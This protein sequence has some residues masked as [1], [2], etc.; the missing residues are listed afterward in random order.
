MNQ[1]ILTQFVRLFTLGD[2]AATQRVGK[3][4]ALA[5]R[6]PTAYQTQFAEELEERGILTAL[7]EQE[8]RDIALIDALSIED[9]AWENDWK[10]DAAE[11]AEGLNEILTRQQRGYALPTSTLPGGRN[12][13]AEAL[14]ALQDALEVKG[15]ALVLFTLD[16]DSYPLGIVDDAQAEEARRL[17]KKLGFNITVY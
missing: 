5:L 15:L 2:D 7:P 6:D 11:M 16:S 14:D 4:L 3:R 8:L 1:E 12:R 13:N 10:E 9:L 17:A